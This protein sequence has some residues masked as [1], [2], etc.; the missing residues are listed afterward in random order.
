MCGIV[1]D[2]RHLPR[3]FYYMK[4]LLIAATPKEVAPFIAHYRDQNGQH[5]IDILPTGVG[6]TAATYAITN[7]IRLKKPELIIQAGIAGCFD[8]N[9]P[10]GSVVV[11]KQDVIADLSVIE[12]KQLNTMFDLKLI[13][14]SA[15]PFQNGWL[16]NPNKGLMRL[17][18]LKAVKAASV[19]HITTS[20]PMM[21][22]Y[23]NKFKP[24]IES[25]EGAALHYVCLMENIPF[26]Q[27]RSISNYAG[28]RNK[29]KWNFN[30]SIQNLNRELVSFFNRLKEIEQL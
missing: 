19:N 3:Q 14:R 20:K 22:L 12:N 13:S 17:T 9:I 23:K 18:G 24:V 1:R 27:I 21:K 5:D 30:D 8:K 29:A 7:Q 11:V 26:L 15:A 16:V 28:Q 25:M 10:L 6:L 2:S 4:C